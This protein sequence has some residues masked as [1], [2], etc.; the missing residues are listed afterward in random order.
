MALS[1]IL[2]LYETILLTF[3]HFVENVLPREWIVQF[4]NIY[5]KIINIQSSIYPNLNNFLI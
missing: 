2:L 1:V 4:D 3:V 5:F